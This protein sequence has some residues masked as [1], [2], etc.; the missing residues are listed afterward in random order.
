MPPA[1]DRD[2]DGLILDLGDA[3]PTDYSSMGLAKDAHGASKAGK[4]SLMAGFSLPLCLIAGL[5]GYVSGGA[6]WGLAGAAGGIFGGSILGFVVHTL[7]ESAGDFAGS[8]I[9]LGSRP[10]WSLREKLSAD[11]QRVRYSL[12]N[13]RYGEAL[14]I[15]DQVLKKD[16]S[17]PEAL[18]LKARALWEGFE[19]PAPARECLRRLIAETPPDDPHRKWAAQLYQNIRGAR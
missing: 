6:A 18:Y 5:Y 3:A 7:A 17:N 11:V 15:A 4:A 8:F 16:P 9:F 14:G 12:G 10:S 1:K 2:S 19:S 13:R